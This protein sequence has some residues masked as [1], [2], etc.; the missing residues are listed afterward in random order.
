MNKLKTPRWGDILQSNMPWLILAVL[1]VVFSFF[2]DHFFSLRNIVNILNQ[3]SY[4]I[5]AAMGISL[6]MMS[7]SLDLSTGYQMSMVGVV[8]GLLLTRLALP[9][10]LVIF[11]AILLGIA[12]N[13]ANALLV[14]RMN[15]TLL[16][17]TVG[18]MNIYQGLSYTISDS[19]VISGFP[20]AFKFLGQGY[21]G[22]VPFP[23][24]LT[25]ILFVIMNIFLTRT[26]MGRYVYALGGNAEASR[27]AGINVLGV[28]LMIAGITGAFVALSTLMLISRLG[29][30]QSSVGP[31]TE[32]TVITGVLVGGVSIRGGEGRLSGVVAG[33]LIM[34]I[35]SNGMQM[36]NMGVYAQFI[37][38][39][40]I[41]LLAIGFD[42]FQMKRR[43]LAQSARRREKERTAKE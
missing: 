4:V 3:N 17:V 39:G 40:A 32:F 27:L 11:L 29:T 34:A 9:V 6:I 8:S 12:M 18:T 25:A 22:P 14:H 30:A 36:A 19:M 28:K 33:I 20:A 31:G 38:K 24:I 41:M 10:P 2:T 13:M 42:V 37:V 15:L 21:I 26:Y 7:G 23:I 16:M 1:C 43:Q 5:I 35:L